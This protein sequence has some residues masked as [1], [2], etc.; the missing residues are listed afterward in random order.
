M[1]DWLGRTLPTIAPRP[2][3]A[4][5][6]RDESR[7]YRVVSSLGFAQDGQASSIFWPNQ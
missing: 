7:S 6:S 4:R 3:A 5:V 1:A 2:F